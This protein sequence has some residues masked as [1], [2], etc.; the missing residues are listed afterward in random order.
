MILHLS[1]DEPGPE[2][3]QS[4][5]WC[6]S[7]GLTHSLGPP[8]KRRVG[9]G[10]ASGKLLDMIWKKLNVI[11]NFWKLLSGST[12]FSALFMYFFGLLEG[13]FPD[14]ILQV[15]WEWIR[16][17]A[18]QIISISP[19]FVAKC[20]EMFAFQRQPFIYLFLQQTYI[21]CWPYAKQEGADTHKYIQKSSES[22]IN[23]CINSINQIS[24][25]KWQASWVWQ[26]TCIQQTLFF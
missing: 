12:S 5:A 6:V 16:F 21:Q 19:G 1:N 7:E 13:L 24:S 17:I 11:P 2:S 23:L 9:W 25:Q 26:R 8:T 15:V 18:Y 4:W 3:P 22:Y 14:G 10:R 20:L